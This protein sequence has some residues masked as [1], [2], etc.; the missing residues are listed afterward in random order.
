LFARKDSTLA[1]ILVTGARGAIGR[2]VVALAHARGHQVVGLGHGAWTP[3]A[4]L[5]PNVGWINGGIDSDNLASLARS[6]GLPDTVIHLA[7]GSLVGP[8]VANPGEDFR[9][10]V[11]GMQHLLEWLRLANPAARVVV[12]SSGAVCGDGHSQPI[13][14]A[15][16][17][18]PTSPYGTHKAMAEMLCRSYGR[19]YGMAIAVVRLFSVYGPGLRKQLIW[20]LGRRLVTGERELELGGT[21]HEQRDFIF[22]DDAAKLLLDA[23]A[24]A[25]KAVPVFNGCNGQAV[26]IASIAGLMAAK[27]PGAALRFS[28]NSRPGDPAYLVGDPTLAQAAGLCT[29]TSLGDGLARTSAWISSVAGPVERS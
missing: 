11:Q 29:E 23:T 24:L 4:D 6:Y 3:D 27:F 28:G 25:T 13:Q 20:D 10:T 16:G 21:G 8:S 15:A 1:L 22:I 18:D 5:P 12:A 14:E 2:R 9:R 7:G 17:Y 26:S 19:Q